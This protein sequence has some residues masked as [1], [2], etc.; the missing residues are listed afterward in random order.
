MPDL[1]A[2]ALPSLDTSE[3]VTGNTHLTLDCH[4]PLMT[5]AAPNENPHFSTRDE[6][7]ERRGFWMFYNARNGGEIGY[8]RTY[9]GSGL[10]VLSGPSDCSIALLYSLVFCL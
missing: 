2:M 5:R 10:L 9:G 3:A 6:G 8:G 1:K 7:T 4:P